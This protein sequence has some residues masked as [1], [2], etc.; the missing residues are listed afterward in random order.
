MPTPNAEEMLKEGF[1]GWQTT[2]EGT[3]YRV[4]LPPTK[5]FPLVPRKISRHGLTVGVLMPPYLVAGL[6]P[7]GI[8]VMVCIGSGSRAKL[9]GAG[10]HP[11]WVYADGPYVPEE[12][13]PIIDAALEELS[14]HWPNRMLI[15]R[16]FPDFD[17]TVN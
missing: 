7:Q 15:Y 11:H 17:P 9:P 12:W 16:P 8:D 6:I 3:A 14:E 10:E 4:R 2:P 13:K 5:A 1:W